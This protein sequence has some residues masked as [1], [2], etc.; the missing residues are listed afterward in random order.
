MNKDAIL[1]YLKNHKDEFAQKYHISNLALFGSFARNE[2]REDSDIDI[3]IDT[4]LSD[5]FLLYDFKES[6]EKAFD[7]KV[8]IVRLREKM[9]PTLKK[10][11]LRD[12]IYV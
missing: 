5:Y 6:L 3:A 2:N 1:T 4:K 8:D 10:R 12:G 9:N 7:A 11:I